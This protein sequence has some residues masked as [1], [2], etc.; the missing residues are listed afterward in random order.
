MPEHQESEDDLALWMRELPSVIPWIEEVKSRI[1]RVCDPKNPL[2][3]ERKYQELLKMT[4]GL[5]FLSKRLLALA[6]TANKAADSMV[7]KEAN[8]QPGSQS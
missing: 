1:D 7:S 3:P 2:E 6:Q 4:E 5:L 8:K